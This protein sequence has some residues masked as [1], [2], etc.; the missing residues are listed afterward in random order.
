MSAK[1]LLPLKCYDNAGRILPPVGLW[2]TILYLSKAL[3]VLIASL[4]FAQDRGAIL[5]LFYPVKSD[6]YVGLMISLAG[7]SGFLLCGF[8]EKI[9]RNNRH[10]LFSL[11]K[12]LLIIALLADLIF[13]LYLANQHKWAFSWALGLSALMDM[14]VLYWVVTSKHLAYML[15]DWKFELDSTSH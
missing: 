9:W 5:G 15:L 4:T 7:L 14:L 10:S 2:I 6:L 1:L 13:Q 12:P 8:R 11:V 3:F